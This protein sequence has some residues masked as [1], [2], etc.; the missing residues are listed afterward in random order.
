MDYEPAEY[1]KLA[2]KQYPPRALRDTAEGKYWKRFGNPVS[3][4]Q[5]MCSRLTLVLE[6]SYYRQYMLSKPRCASL[7]NEER[8]CKPLAGWCRLPHR[9][10]Q[11]VALSFCSH[12]VNSGKQRRPAICCRDTDSA[13][14][15]SLTCCWPQVIVYN[16][17]TRKVQR[18][19]TRFKDKA[20]CGNFRADNKLLVAGGEDGT[21]QVCACTPPAP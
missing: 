16:A 14:Y 5:V 21:V 12:S 3:H 20:Y 1:R 7:S 18:Q 10:Q 19:F 6:L 15:I 4:Q 17:V 11:S 13:P 2:L 9:L 8:C